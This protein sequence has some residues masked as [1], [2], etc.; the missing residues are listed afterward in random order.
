[1]DL[2]NLRCFIAVA[3]A[4]HFARAAERLY[5]DQS[6]LSRAIRRVLRTAHTGPQIA[7]HQPAELGRTAAL[8]SEPLI[9]QRQ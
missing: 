1:M 2:R 7:G 3:K 5:L 4:L 6:R 9:D 8:E